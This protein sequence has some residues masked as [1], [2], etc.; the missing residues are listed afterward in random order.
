MADQA[1][2]WG[3]R[4][5]GSPQCLLREQRQTAEWGEESRRRQMVCDAMPRSDPEAHWPHAAGVGWESVGKLWG[6][7][8][9]S[10]ADAPKG[11]PL[12]RDRGMAGKGLQANQ[13]KQ[14]LTGKAAHSSPA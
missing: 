3:P 8:C 14:L 7:V 1:A 4:V 2:F 9:P 12:P 6:G 5:L 11:G 13:K 10:S